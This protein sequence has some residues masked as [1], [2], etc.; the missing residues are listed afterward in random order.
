M[1]SRSATAYQVRNGVK[2]IKKAIA[3]RESFK[4]I[5]IYTTLPISVAP[6]VL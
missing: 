3:D 1:H 2:G 6:Y 4:N 5:F